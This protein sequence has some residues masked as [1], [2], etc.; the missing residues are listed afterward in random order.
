MSAEAFYS[1]KEVNT[2]IANAFDQS[3]IQFP[4][5]GYCISLMNILP[6][7]PINLLG[8]LDLLS[9]WFCVILLG[10]VIDIES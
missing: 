6:S 9:A 3:C 7:S 4:R 5:A 2:R 1:R 8:P 10:H